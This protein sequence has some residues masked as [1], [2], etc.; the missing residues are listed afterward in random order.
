MMFYWLRRQERRRAIGSFSFI[1]MFVFY[2]P[3]QPQQ[4]QQSVAGLRQPQERIG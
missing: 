2:S 4:Q 3:D 1:V